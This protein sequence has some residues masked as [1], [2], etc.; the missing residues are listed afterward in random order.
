MPSGAPVNLICV[1]QFSE[2]IVYNVVLSTNQRQQVEG[3]LAW[4]W[5]LQGSLPANHPFKRWPP[6]P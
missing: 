5:G 4:K 3:Y 2:C 1:S 6:S